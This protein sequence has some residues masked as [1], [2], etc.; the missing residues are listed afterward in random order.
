MTINVTKIVS[1]DLFVKNESLLFDRLRAEKLQAIIPSIGAVTYTAMASDTSETLEKLAAVCGN[2]AV[3]L[4]KS[5]LGPEFRLWLFVSDGAWREANRITKYHKLWKSHRDLTEAIDPLKISEEAELE[6]GE[7]IRYAGLLEISDH[8][9]SIAINAVRTNS[10]FAMIFSKRADIDSSQGI[11]SIF[12]SAFP[13]KDGVEQERI[14][15][16]TL[17]LGSCTQG[18]ILLR[19]SGLF[20]DREVAV[21]IIASEDIILK[22]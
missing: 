11:R 18:D 10:S 4:A 21:D 2:E 12:A 5:S 22:L 17:A 3:A 8:S 16:L 13:K 6:S 14:D 1:P 9:C 7:L 15:W 19:V 20:D